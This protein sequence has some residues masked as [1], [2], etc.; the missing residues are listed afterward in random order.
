MTQ[1]DI[2]GRPTDLS[3]Q[4]EDALDRV[5][6]RGRVQLARR[7]EHAQHLD[8]DIRTRRQAAAPPP[9][10]WTRGVSG[11]R[12]EERPFHHRAVVPSVLRAVTTMT[13]PEER[14]D[15][16]WLLLLL[17]MM[18]SCYVMLCHGVQRETETDSSSP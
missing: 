5:A 12:E 10:K 18:V 15:G 1:H 14:D 16:D 4:R 13:T 9:E 2:P 7:A 6:P 8:S 11:G 17:R 3:H